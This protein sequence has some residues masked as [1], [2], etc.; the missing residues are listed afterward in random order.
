MQN[1]ADGPPVNP[2]S[3]VDQETPNRYEI[4]L[5][6]RGVHKYMSVMTTTVLMMYFSCNSYPLLC[7]M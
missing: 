1:S 5:K 3:V 7:N 2:D 6:V 4:L